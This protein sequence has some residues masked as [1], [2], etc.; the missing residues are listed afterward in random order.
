M[1]SKRGRGVSDLPGVCFDTLVGMPHGIPGSAIRGHT[2]RNAVSNGEFDPVQGMHIVM[3]K[4]AV[5][6][7]DQCKD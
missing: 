1:N 2:I 6:I 3:Q 4:E 7:V 5:A